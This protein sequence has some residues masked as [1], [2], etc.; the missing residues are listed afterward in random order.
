MQLF[1]SSY[2]NQN[3][4]SSSLAVY[5]FFFG[6]LMLFSIIRFWT[7]GWIKELY[8]DPSFHFS[9]Y[10]FEWIKPVGDSTYLIFFICLISSLFVCIGYKYR[11]SIV[12]FFLSFSYIEL[13]DKTTYLNHYYLISCLSFLLIFLPAHASFSLD[14]LIRKKSYSTIPKWTVDIIKLMISIV[15]LYAAIAKINSDWLLNAMP[16]KIWISSK[17]HFLFVGETLFQQDWLYYLMSWSGMFYDLLIPLLLLYRKTRLVGFILVVIFHVLTKFLF[18]IG[19]FPY[20]MIFSAIIFFSPN[21]HDTIVNKP[22]CTI[23]L[24]TSPILL[25]FSTLSVSVKPRSLFRP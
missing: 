3:T 4:S 12:I 19:M 7:K 13:M 10:G 22:D 18:P 20:I 25:M 14:S 23:S 11:F 17:Y 1:F 24:D 15:Y 2:F 9:Y 8:L 5:R 16:L 6:L 21:F